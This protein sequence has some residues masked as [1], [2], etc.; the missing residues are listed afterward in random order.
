[1]NRCFT[2]IQVLIATCFFLTSLG[3]G[4]ASSSGAR[5][6]N[7]CMPSTA[8]ARAS[9]G[10]A[11]SN[12]WSF[13]VFGDTRDATRNTQTGISPLF[14]RMA[15]AIAAEKPALVIHIG[16]LINGFYTSKKS[17][18]HGKYSEMFEN[19]KTAVKPIYDFGRRTGIPLY[20][21]RGNHEDGELVTDK[22]LKT[23]YLKSIASF[24]P[25]N[26]PDRKRGLHT[27]FRTN[28]PRLLLSTS[29]PSRN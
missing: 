8:A 2:K 12:R 26:G 17:P 9:S 6:N 27:A 20:A 10:S 23:A 25:Q 28:K 18:I 21:V 16:D 24:M 19:W 13:V 1:M 29:I 14:G 15:E 7:P 22:R 11:E 5:Q 3:P 4:D